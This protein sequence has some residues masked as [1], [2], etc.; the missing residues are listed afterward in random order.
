MTLP[1]ARAGALVEAHGRTFAQDAG[2]ALADEPD[3]LWQLLV[4]A[5]LLSARIPSATAVRASRTLLDAG[6]IASTAPLRASSWSQR[7]AVLGRGGYKRYDFS[8]ATRLDANARLLDERWGGDLRRL[9]DEAGS[10][11][12]IA[13]ALQ[14]FDGIGPAGA[15]IFLREAQAVWPSVRP[16]FD[17]LALKGAAL[18]DLPTDAHALADL[19]PSDDLARLAAA[20][21]KVAKKP[22]LLAERP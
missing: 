2:I 16:F 9:R 18:A 3:T 6:L 7:V 21:V 1:A 11:D 19:V 10:V 15:S 4:L 17:A 22:A 14:T 13:R 5:Q 8:T 12:G 20:L